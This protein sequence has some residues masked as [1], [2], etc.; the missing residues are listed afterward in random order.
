MSA[1]SHDLL[2]GPSDASGD[3][4]PGL[5]LELCADIA[6]TAAQ[7]ARAW[8]GDTTWSGLGGFDSTGGFWLEPTPEGLLRFLRTPLCLGWL[9]D[10]DPPPSDSLAAKFPASSPPLGAEAPASFP[11]L[12]AHVA[13]LPGFAG[14]ALRHPVTGLWKPVIA[15][16]DTARLAV[17]TRAFTPLSRILSSQGLPVGRLL[18]LT[19]RSAAL[20]WRTPGKIYGYLHLNEPSS[21]PFATTLADH[22]LLCTALADQD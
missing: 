5:D 10:L 14:C 11:S 2:V 12:Q 20:A 18:L 1:P 9:R 13:A 19:N 22:L 16:P 4:S 6:R 17:A 15:P 7:T 8:A 3:R 21:L